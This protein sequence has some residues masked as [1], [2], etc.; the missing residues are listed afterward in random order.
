MTEQENE[1]KIAKAFNE[2]YI[3]SKHEPELLSKI[4]KS[5]NQSSEYMLAMK[6]GK[7]QHDQEK[8]IQEQQRIKERQMQQRP[9]H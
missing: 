1:K 5:N 6:A 7:K 3:M 9:K 8:L 2:G 4:F